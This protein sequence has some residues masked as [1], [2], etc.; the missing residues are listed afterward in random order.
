MRTEEKVEERRPPAPSAAAPAL[1]KR[2]LWSFRYLWRTEVH[3]YAFSIAANALLSFFPFTLLLVTIC[4]SW[5]HWQGAYD[6]VVELLRANL[7]TGADFVIRNLVVVMR[8]RRPVQAASVLLLFITSSGVFLPLEVALNKIWGIRRDRSFLGNFAVSVML[9]VGS[10][11]IAFAS[12]VLGAVTTAAFPVAVGQSQWPGLATA[13]ARATLETI[14]IPLM[15]GIYFAVYY[16]LPNGRVPVG[17]A[18]PAAVVAALL[19]ELVRF[20]YAWVL[21]V[22]HFP[23][24]YGPFA[25]SATLLIWAFLGALILLWGASFFACGFE[26]SRPPQTDAH[27]ARGHILRLEI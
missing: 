4:H 27:A 1:G 16:A 3:A 8:A 9:A 24:V 6:F 2:F 17:R 12:V 13:A 5:L 20:V 7:P 25:L 14:S 18:L 23:E 19:T 26:L 15:V 22:F 21:P 11:I 10:G